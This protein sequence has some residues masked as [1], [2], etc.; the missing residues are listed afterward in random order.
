MSTKINIINIRNIGSA[1]H[2]DNGKTTLTERIIYLTGLS[3]KVGEVHHGNTTTDWMKQERERGITITSA[4]ITTDWNDHR[5]G[6]IDTPG[7]VDFQ[8]E[9]SRCLRVLDG[10]ICL[11]DAVSGVE[12]Q[13]QKVWAQ[14]D[15]YK[16][17]RICFINKMDRVG[18]DFFKSVESIKDKLRANPVPTQIPIGSGPNF[19]GVVDLIT[20]KAIIWD[21]E[22]LGS[23]FEVTDIPEELKDQAQLNRDY[24]LDFAVNYDDELM[25]MVLEDKP[26]PPEKIVTALRIATLKMEITPVLCGSAFK[27][28]GVQPL[29]D[30]VIDYLP[31]P[32]DIEAIEGVDPRDNNNIQRLPDE[33][34]PL[35]AL[36]FKL[37]SPPPPAVGQL[38]YIRVYSG[39]LNSGDMVLNVAK[40]KIER[41]GRLVRMHADKQ[42]T[43][44]YVTAGNIAAIIGMKTATTGDTISSPSNPILLESMDFPDPVMGVAIEPKTQ[45]DN[46][47]L[48]ISLQ[49]LAKEDYKI[50][51]IN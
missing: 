50:K 25:E 26:I 35:S 5:F 34:E 36:V 22:D 4:A 16:V 6:I 33:K 31:S 42:E 15:R 24:L 1:A 18:A 43:I 39:V 8:I 47:K 9:V 48:S 13:T 30:A 45:A 23:K 10:M 40:N 29:L 21:G 38:T 51:K 37:M 17:P 49:K 3:Y 28:K 27:N 41:V 19:V 46:Q 11:L 7:H 44:E 20:N 2:V 12:P 32:L 14:A